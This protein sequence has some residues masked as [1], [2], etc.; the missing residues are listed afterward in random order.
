[1]VHIDAFQFQIVGIPVRYCPFL[2][3]GVGTLPLLTD[4]DASRTVVFERWVVAIVTTALHG[5]PDTMEPCAGVT[6]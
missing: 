3:G 5:F 4:S 6:V 2:E 1:L